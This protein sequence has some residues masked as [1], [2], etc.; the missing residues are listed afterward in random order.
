MHMCNAMGNALD[1]CKTSLPIFVIRKNYS[2]GSLFFPMSNKLFPRFWGSLFQWP[3]QLS[4]VI[5]SAII[6]KYY[7]NEHEKKV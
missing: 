3:Y 5:I 4:V 7:G 2:L 1:D 6:H